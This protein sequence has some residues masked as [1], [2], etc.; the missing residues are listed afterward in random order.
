MN[1]WTLFLDRDGVINT[2]II[3][4][5]VRNWRE[6]EFMEG[7]LE[8]MPIFKA[9]FAQVVVVTNQQGIAKGLM[10]A[11]DLEQVHQKMLQA[12]A[13]A[14]GQIVKA[15]YCPLHERENPHCRKPNSGMAEQAQKDFPAIDFKKSIMVGDSPS[16]IEF[17]YRLGMKTIFI[18]S[19]QDIPEAELSKIQ[20][21]I[22]FTFDSLYSFSQHLD[23]ILV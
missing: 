21:K 9:N 8:A 4:S 12:I 15:Y 6:F 23:T 7:V 11:A 16:D 20:P 17:G 1:N 10:T 14:G 5:Y 13:N 2:R 22:S 19:R 18:S 3:G